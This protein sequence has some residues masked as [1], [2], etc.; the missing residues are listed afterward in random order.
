[1]TS[2]DRK[3]VENKPGWI[4]TPGEA[5]WSPALDYSF[6]INDIGECTIY[7]VDIGDYS[8][9][10]AWITADNAVGLAGVR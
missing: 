1:M 7:P 4:N 5:G 6:K 3:L 10:T 9:T 8:L 2:T